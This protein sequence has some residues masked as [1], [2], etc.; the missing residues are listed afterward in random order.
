MIGEIISAA[1]P[2][3]MGGL[4]RLLRGEKIRTYVD[5]SVIDPEIQK[6]PYSVYSFLL[7]AGYLKAAVVY[8]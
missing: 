1:T 6:N 3:V 8:P 4:Q 7:I 2:E 5:T